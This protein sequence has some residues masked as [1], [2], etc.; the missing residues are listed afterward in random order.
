MSHN[1]RNLNVEVLR[2][3]AMLL[4]ILGHCIGHNHL[5]EQSG[6]VSHYLLKLLQ[7]VSYPATNIFVLISGY[8]Q[9]QTTFKPQK[10]FLLW[11]QVF[12]YSVG[13]YMLAIFFNWT[14][15]HGKE[16]LKVLLPISGNQYWFI[17]VYLGMY[18]LSPFLNELV[19]A[20]DKRKFLW[21]LMVHLAIFSLWRSFIPFATTLNTEGGASILWFITLYL[22]G[23]YLAI[24]PPC[25]CQKVLI[26]LACAFLM[27]AFGSWATISWLSYHL[28]FAGKGSSLFTE[29]TAFPIYGFATCVFLLAIAKKDQ[30][31]NLFLR[32]LIMVCSA[33]TLG[34]YM[35]HENI[36]VKRQLWTWL[37]LPS[38]INNFQIFPIVLCL[39]VMI[40]LVCT[41]IDLLTWNWVRR[42]FLDF[43]HAACCLIQKRA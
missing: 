6:G 9:S 23:A 12:F 7:I 43:V 15:F 18:L 19:R 42:F 4:I 36:Y 40:Y 26:T 39:T 5:V 35:L 29:F 16:L 41:I 14:H 13:L 11:L 17:R 33:S 28:G 34:V 25:I 31:N 27:F 10:L 24:F 3:V 1:S 32:K 8:F 2:I 20:L 30:W 21:L 38:K 37:D 22:T